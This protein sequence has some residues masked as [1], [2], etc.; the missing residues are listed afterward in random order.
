MSVTSPD[1]DEVAAL[2]YVL[3]YVFNIPTDSPV[4]PALK[5]FWI[6]DIH[7]FVTLDPRRD[8]QETYHYTTTNEETGKEEENY[9]N[10]PAMFIR[11]IELFQEWFRSKFPANFKI[12]FDM[13]AQK[14]KIW[15]N[16]HVFNTTVNI[17][18]EP[19]PDP[20]NSSYDSD[21]T[22]HASGSTSNDAALFLRS[23]K[24][25][26]TDYQKFKEDNKWK[27]WHRSLRATVGAHGL[28][29]ILDSTYKP[30]TH[31]E[32]LLYNAQN[33]FMYSVFEQCLN[34]TKSRQI[35]Q[36]HDCDAD[37][38]KVYVE[39]IAAYEETLTTSLAATELR[40]EITLLRFDD[41]WKKGSEA[42]LLHWQ[43]KILELEQLEDKPIEDSTKRLWLTSTLSTKTHMANCLNQAKVTELTILGMDTTSTIQEM[44]WENFYKLILAH[45]KM[46][47][48]ATPTKSRRETNFTARSGRGSP[49]GWSR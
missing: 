38:S 42:F 19:V 32:Q 35:V 41:S 17:K 16:L 37:A 46:H 4:Y 3:E 18:T 20:V 34:T 48:H 13:N 40:G 22:E 30:S 24:R 7:D 6:L 2:Q 25:S 39:L 45:A 1:T 36:R 8:L 31:D 33:T 47:D 28:S 29:N 26:P 21:K 27:Q 9:F 11:N 5:S 43:G 44:P 12:V 10:T 49:R 14:F 15:K 23:I